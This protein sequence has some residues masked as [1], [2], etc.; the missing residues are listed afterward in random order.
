MTNI[1]KPS[2]LT[3]P[4]PS[5]ASRP[6]KAYLN[7]TIT[8]RAGAGNAYP[9][10]DVLHKGQQITLWEPKEVASD[11]SVWVYFEYIFEGL[12]KGAW[13]NSASLNI[14]FHPPTVEVKAV[15]VEGVTKPLN[16]APKSTSEI[17][18]VPA[19]PAPALPLINVS[20][21]Q[22]PFW[23]LY[24]QGLRDDAARFLARADDLE[25]Q[26]NLTVKEGV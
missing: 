9:K 11:G 1:P 25:K 14:T 18:Q 20:V 16:D 19:A 8:G 7:T 5:N 24:I 21:D 2:I 4:K 13:I 3:M 22:M 17:A 10:M 23:K 12:P 15:Q 6:L 26:L